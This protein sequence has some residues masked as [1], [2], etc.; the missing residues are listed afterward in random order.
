MLTS[1][2]LKREKMKAKTSQDLSKKPA[3]SPVI[4]TN[5]EHSETSHKKLLAPLSATVYE[6]SLFEKV[7]IDYCAYK[8]CNKNR[9]VGFSF[10]PFPKDLAKWVHSV[11]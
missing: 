5:P 10:Q 8:G 2:L 3:E 11:S 6:N 4:Q 7:P 9:T 1:Y